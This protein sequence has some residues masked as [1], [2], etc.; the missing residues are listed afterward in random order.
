M[1]SLKRKILLLIATS[2]ILVGL[3]SVVHADNDARSMVT[4][5]KSPYCGC[6][7]KWVEHMRRNGF[8]V[9]VEDVFDISAVKLIAG[10]PGDL[11]A[12]HTASVAGYVVEGHVPSVD[13]ARLLAQRPAATGIAVPGMPVG[14]PGMEQGSN[15]DTFDVIL[16]FRAAR[17][18]SA[19]Y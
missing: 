7:K 12:C 10:I 8:S 16:F 14:S 18:I 11:E 3:G 19:S 15:S 1:R 2:L 5:Y 13:V 17:N 9:L 4:V 6:C